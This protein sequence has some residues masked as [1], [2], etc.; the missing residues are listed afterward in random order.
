[1]RISIGI[2]AV[3]LMLSGCAG[4]LI[5]AL[6]DGTG[7]SGSIL[8]PGPSDDAGAIEVLSEM[9][10]PSEIAR[11]IEY[12][13]IEASG[14]HR[15][16]KVAAGLV[17]EYTD[18]IPDFIPNFKRVS[19]EC[20]AVFGIAELARL[21]FV[22]GEI[23]ADVHPSLRGIKSHAGRY[24][25]VHTYDPHPPTEEEFFA[26][27]GNSPSAYATFTAAVV[28]YEEIGRPQQIVASIEE[29]LGYCF[30]KYETN[31]VD[32]TSIGPTEFFNEAK[33]NGT[34]DFRGSVPALWYSYVH[35]FGSTGGA[36]PPF[37]NE[38]IA[39]IA[40]DKYLLIQSITVS[41]HAQ[42]TL[43]IDWD[44]LWTAIDSFENDFWEVFN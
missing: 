30:P 31:T 38:G 26:Q 16:W 9:R 24:F 19:Q 23:E 34:P 17:T 8:T 35:I 32:L 44:E 29:N 5:D 20:G 6:S 42:R 28:E 4:T 36:E 18:G 1:M 10:K 25:A 3:S 2:A 11:F 7:D 12:D 40:Q 15:P 13:E 21:G 43:Q 37:S 33:L 39:L 41:Q 22:S 14:K 27:L